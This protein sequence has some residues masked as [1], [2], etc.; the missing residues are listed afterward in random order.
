MF[1][2]RNRAKIAGVAHPDKVEHMPRLQARLEVGGGS[3]CGVPTARKEV[4]VPFV[5]ATRTFYPA[6]DVG[7]ALDRDRRNT[8]TRR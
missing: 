4:Q 5:I 1:E 8:A 2:G 6:T 3:N 7:L